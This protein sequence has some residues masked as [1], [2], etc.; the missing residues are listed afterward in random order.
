MK[1]RQAT[2]ED[3][4][5]IQRLNH[6]LFLHDSK[7]DFKLD[8]DWNFSTEGKK[9]FQKVTSDNNYLTVIAEENNKVIGYVTTE[10]KDDY[11][12][13]KDKGQIFEICN[14][15]VE[16]EHRKQGIGQKLIDFAE[17]EARSKGI[18]KFTVSAHCMNENALAFYKRIGYIC[19]TIILE[20]ED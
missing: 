3:W 16:E 20:K 7:F 8:M 4:E 1:I 12:Y 14:I 10:I 19:D 6:A 5:E 13:K 17:K 15:F 11:S 18:K 9:Y 2:I